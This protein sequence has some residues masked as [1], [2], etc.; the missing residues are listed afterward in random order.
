MVAAD[1]VRST[2]RGWLYPASRAS[3]R[4]PHRLADGDGTVPPL[5]D[6]AV[7]WGRGERFG[8]VSLPRGRVYCFGTA[9]LPAGEAS[10]PA[11]EH[12]EVMRRFGTGPAPIPPCWRRSSRAVLRHDIY[13]LPPCRRTCKGESRCWRRGP[14][15]DAESRAGRC[16]ALEDAVVLADCLQRQPDVPA[17]LARYD[18]RGGR[19]PR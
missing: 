8:Y 2:V 19:A 18:D 16:Q 14:R 4:R 3:V 17:A 10:R 15:D 5:A 7:V 11:G 6:G 13:D 9:S 12:A 1:G